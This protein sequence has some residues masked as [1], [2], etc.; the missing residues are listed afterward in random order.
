MFGNLY[1]CKYSKG[2][3]HPITGREGQ[4]RGELKYGSTVSLNSA[5]D[6][7]WVVNATPRPLY[8]RERDPV[9]IIQEAGWTPWRS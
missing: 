5:L 4:E 2:K 3:G 1:K 7:R 9:A 8:F 6:W